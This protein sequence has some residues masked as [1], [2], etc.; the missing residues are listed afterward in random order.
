MLSC[1]APIHGQEENIGNLFL[2]ADT[3]A[4][5]TE[6]AVGGFL[7]NSALNSAGAAF[8]TLVDTAK[9]NFGEPAIDEPKADSTVTPAVGGDPSINPATSGQS[10]V[11]QTNGLLKNP[12]EVTTKPSL[13]PLSDPPESETPVDIELSVTGDRYGKPTLRDPECDPNKSQASLHAVQHSNLRGKSDE[14]ADS[15]D[16]HFRLLLAA[17]LVTNPLLK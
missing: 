7:L 17:A 14:L 15:C 12:G 11:E 10:T 9:N 16:F 2:D 5:K 1:P 13:N 6:F 8:N 4:I 3:T